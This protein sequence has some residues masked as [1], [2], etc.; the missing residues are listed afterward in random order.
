MT[1]MPTATVPVY[2]IHNWSIHYENH[3]TRKFKSLQWIPVSNKHGDGFAELMD[4][5]RGDRHFAA[6]ILILQVASRTVQRGVLIRQVGDTLAAH[7]AKSLARMVRM[8]CAVVQE[9]LGRLIA[10]GW[11]EQIECSPG[12]KPG[13]PGDSPGVPEDAG[14]KALLNR[15]ELNIIDRDNPPVGGCSLESLEKGKLEKLLD[16]L[17]V[18]SGK[19]QQKRWLALAE[20]EGGAQSLQERLFCIEWSV[21]T[22]RRR[23]GLKVN[24]ANQVI[25]HAREWGRMVRKAGEARK[26]QAS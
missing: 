23:D 1:T 7:D 8:D 3:D 9:A 6:W 19:A 12:E 25:A 10:L 13:V 14:R 5:E 18:A 22:A 11:L 4:H 17:L 26:E 21:D 2:R 16:S 24:Y 15:I 20:H